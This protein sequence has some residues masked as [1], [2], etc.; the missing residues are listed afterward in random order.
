MVLP[1]P[2]QQSYMVPKIIKATLIKTI[3]I[4]PDLIIRRMA[5]IIMQD[6][7][8]IRIIIHIMETDRMPRIIPTPYVSTVVTLVI[9]GLLATTTYSGQRC[10]YKTFVLIIIL[11][12]NHVVVLYP[13]IKYIAVTS[14]VVV[15]QPFNVKL[16]RQIR[17][18]I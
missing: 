6:R 3:L 13:A 16:H 15:M 9:P 18:E 10:L 17:Y 7:L 5:I 11:W 4:V 14:V 12:A 1:L 2:K 8:I